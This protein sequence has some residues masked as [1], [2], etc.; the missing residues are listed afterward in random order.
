MSTR[1][2]TGVSGPRAPTSPNDAPDVPS[3][4]PASS[5][6]L[7]DGFTAPTKP[8]V[9]IAPSVPGS[10]EVNGVTIVTHGC[11]FAALAE[12]E[13]VTRLLT[14]RPDLGKK[15]DAKDVTL[16]IIPF[17]QKMTDLPEFASL[18]GKKTFDGRPWETVRGSGGLR[19][20]G[21]VFVGVAEENLAQLGINAYP[22]GYSIAMHELAHALQNYA[23]PRAD[24]KAIDR[25]FEAREAAGGP[26]TEAYGASNEEEYFAQLTTAWFGRNSGVG[27]NGAD[28][29]RSA[30][31]AMAATLQQIYGDPSRPPPTG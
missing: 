27:H 26:W 31:P 5:P 29:V 3:L 8:N 11:S 1:P 20:G 19:A 13:N 6:V 21:K 12:A 25:A 28:W 18:R 15:L 7:G 4:A 2:T 10:V 24:Q 9:V 14:H 22:S 30:D 23:L 16:V 17:G